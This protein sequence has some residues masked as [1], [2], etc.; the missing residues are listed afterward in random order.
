[1]DNLTA[2]FRSVFVDNVVV[3][4]DAGASI[5]KRSFGCSP[6]FA[7][8]VRRR[9]KLMVNS[10]F[11]DLPIL[12]RQPKPRETGINYVRAPVMAGR[13]VEDYLAAFGEMVDIFKLSG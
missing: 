2:N 3:G 1:M 9:I 6:R 12:D 5:S 7:L 4:N 13:V 11:K 8:V 10:Y